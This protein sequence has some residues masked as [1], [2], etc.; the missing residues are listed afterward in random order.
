MMPAWFQ[1]MNRRER[2]LAAG[3]A[4]ILFLLVN[5]GVWS[6]LFG[7]L[8]SARSELGVRQRARAEQDAYLKDY[9][10]WV[11]RDKWLRQHQPVLKSAGEASTLLDQAKEIANKYNVLIEN[12]SIGSG[13]STGYHQ[14]VFAAIETKSPWP[15]LVHFFYDVQQPEGFIVFENVN[16]QI[17]SGDPTMMRGKLKIARWFAPGPKKGS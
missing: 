2:M 5:I 6:T 13:D 1:R 11:K 10:R 12:P 3:V 9:D 4:G 14:S 16:L 17:D 15:P 8:G 7:M